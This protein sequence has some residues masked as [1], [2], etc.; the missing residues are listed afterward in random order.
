MNWN[1]KRMKPEN[2]ERMIREG[3]THLKFCMML[4]Q[5]QID[6]GMYFL[7]EHPYSA[8]SWKEECVQ[9]IMNQEK[10]RVVRGDMCAFGMWQNT[11]EGKR[12][13]MKPTGFMTNAEGIANELN[14]KCEG[15]HTHVKLL[16]GRAHRAEVYPDELCFKIIK[17]LMETMKK[18]GR[19][20]ADG[21]GAVMAE[22]ECRAFDDITGEEL[23]HREVRKA[24]ELEVSEVHKHEVYVK[25]PIKTC[26]DKTGKAPIKTRW[27]DINKGDEVHPDYRSRFVAKD[28]NDRWTC[29]Q[30]PH[31]WRH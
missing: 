11:E 16:N 4:Y 10:V 7:H 8:S 18:D 25:T 31:H 30:Q 12:L 19:I 13:V 22:E 9:E 21:I 6:N 27:I 14:T 3:K 29:L 28:F 5:I 24:R 23:D 15:N 2:R 26:W 20:H 1:W 17:G